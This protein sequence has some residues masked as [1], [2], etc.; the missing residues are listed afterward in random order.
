MGRVTTYDYDLRNRLWRTNETV[1]SVPR[2]TETLYDTAGNKT[3]VIF[4]DLKTQ[5]WRDYDAFGQPGRFIDERLYTTN[6]T[7]IWGPMKKPRTVTT[8]RLK[9]DGGT[10]DQVTTFAYDPMGRPQNIIFPD[11]TN[12][13]KHYLYGQVDLFK[14]RKNQ[15]K[16]VFYDTRGREAYHTW[17][18]NT[19]PRIDREWDNA[20]RMTRI[21]N[22]FSTIDFTYDAAGQLQTETNNVSGSAERSL[23]T[24]SVTAPVT[25]R[26]WFFHLA[27]PGFARIIVREGSRPRGWRMGRATGSF[28]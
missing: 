21:S 24:T 13:F 3:D 25:C 4:P 12:E 1:N 20:S 15:I 23:P 11:G 28:N 7:Y 2:T 10:E 9:D 5:Q 8:H 22:V 14:T 16:R 6:Y 26:I 17:D 27:G 19:A 18:G